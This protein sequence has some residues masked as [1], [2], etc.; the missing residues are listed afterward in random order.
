MRSPARL[1][2][3]VVLAASPAPPVPRPVPRLWVLRSSA[4]SA[5]TPYVGLIG[6][7][8]AS[9]LAGPLADALGRRDVG[10]VIA[11]VGGCQPT[12]LVLT[13]QS[14]A[15]FQDHRHCAEDAKQVQQEL[16]RRYA[17]KV[18]VWSD[19][20]EWSDIQADDRLVPAGG[21]EWR[22]T[23]LGAWDRTLSRLGSAGVVLV[24]PTW[25]AGWPPGYPAAFPVDR[26]RWLFRSWAARRHGR[27]TVVDPAPLLCPSGPPCPQVVDGVRL[28][29]DSVHY[30]PEGAR[31]V[32]AKILEDATALR[33]LHGPAPSVSGRDRCGSSAGSSSGGGRAGC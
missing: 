1:L 9:Q 25:W 14:A 3:S 30:S 24:L 17:P 29:T 22:R 7:S 28:R 11:T 33:T 19:V 26:Q 21:E 2:M 18:V 31:R 13:Y 23:M 16:V 8:T 12:D 6:D 4:Q 15:Y 32:T 5:M 20:M 10:V 27:V